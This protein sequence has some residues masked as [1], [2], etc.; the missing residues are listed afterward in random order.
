MDKRIVGLETEYALLHYPRNPAHQKGLTGTEVFELMNGCMDE[1]QIVRLYEE[2]FYPETR[3][4]PFANFEDRRRYSMKKNRMFLSNGARFYL[5]TGDHP[6]YAT[7]ECRGALDLT[8]FDKAGERMVEQLSLG[9]QRRIDD[10][11]LGGDIFVCKNN[12]DV[13]G[14]TFGCHENY[15]IPRR[16]PR[17]NESSFFKLVIKELIPF[18]ISRHIF[19]G[20][21]KVI[22]GNKLGYQISQRADFIDSELSSDTTFRRGII[23]SRDEPLG[24]IDQY[25]RLH[26][27]IGDSNLSELATFLKVGTTMLVLRVIEEEGMDE[28]FALED[29]I[30]SLREISHDPSCRVRVK[31]IDGSYL[32]AVEIQ[33]YYLNRVRKFLEKNGDLETG[34]N[35]L[36]LRHWERMLDTVADD[37]RKLASEIDWAA[38]Q[39]VTDRFLKRNGVT[40]QELNKWVYF[41]KR[42]KS[43]RLEEALFFQNR[44]NPH[45][46]VEEFLRSR[47]SQGDFI[48]LKRHIRYSEIHFQDYFRIH[49]LY[50][51]LLKLDIIF[52]DVNRERGLFYAMRR[53]GQIRKFDYPDIIAHMWDR[54]ERTLKD[55]GLLKPGATAE[56]SAEILFDAIADFGQANPP[57]DTR[58]KIRGEFVRTLYNSNF[59]GAVNWDSV[60]VHDI[61]LRKINL[62]SPFSSSNRNVSDLIAELRRL[63]NLGGSGGE[64]NAGVGTRSTAGRGEES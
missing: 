58:A 24:K 25:R 22:T 54:M 45:F 4:E 49:R 9:A 33:R 56:D 40:Y 11:G 6:E 23:N 17:H 48:E 5:D 64:L 16:S 63:A 13:R 39:S 36:I 62:M 28:G 59:K 21:G 38:K 50:H 60:S 2:K 37:P 20:S 44:S 3:G 52:H 42:M 41:I 35:P 57:A 7:P 1:A 31:M 61:K 53:R 55:A 12:I 14:N 51:R 47:I 10:D 19:C 30:L 15:L 27:L 8:A 32:S 43:L 46:D 29:P 26:I 34:E 18:L